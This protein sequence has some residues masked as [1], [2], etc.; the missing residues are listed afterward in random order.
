MPNRR[1][2]IQQLLFICAGAAILPSCF[3]EEE[4]VSIP[5]TKIKIT[6]GE[7]KMLAELAETII[8]KTDTPGAKDLAAHLFVL[9]MVDDCFEKEKQEKFTLGMKDFETFAKKKSGRSFADSTSEQKQSVV[10]ELDGKNAG[11]DNLSFFYHS[12]KQLTTQAYTS[13][14]FYLTNIRHY[15][16]IPGKF[17]G[18]VPLKVA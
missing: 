7:E 10:A 16:M 14:Q 3:R 18:C 9:N 13:S 5:L 17:Q 8:P 4:K 6:G 11:A 2:A 1:V 12:V 15:K